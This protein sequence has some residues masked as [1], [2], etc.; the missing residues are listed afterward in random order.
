MLFVVD[1]FNLVVFVVAFATEFVVVFAVVFV[2]VFAV[3]DVVAPGFNTS[4]PVA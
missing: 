3:F 1:V 4:P 2:V